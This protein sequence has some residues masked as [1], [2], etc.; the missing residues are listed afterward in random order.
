M[1]RPVLVVVAGALAVGVAGLAYVRASARTA[2][3]STGPI[4]ER[5]VAEA[6]VVPKGGV[7]DVASHDAGRAAR[8]LAREGEHVDK[9]QTLVELDALDGAPKD[10]KPDAVVAPIAGVVLARHVE[11]GDVVPDEAHGG[12]PLFTLADPSATELRVEVDEEDADRVA[13]GLSVVVTRPGGGEAIAKGHVTRVSARIE[14]RTIGAGDARVRAASGVRAAWVAWDEAPRAAQP[15]GRRLEAEIRLAAPRT[16]ARVPKSAVVV[17]DGRTV[18]EV[19]WG[20]WFRDRAVEVVST[21]GSLAEIRG[22]PD[23]TLVLV[24]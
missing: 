12:P 3:V 7:T 2:T 8:V 21:D 1:K 5:L 13:P 4:G 20:P 16:G 11:P 17:R 23:G 18:V 19:P 10:A 15:L 24:H 9:G 14:P 22:I 6:V